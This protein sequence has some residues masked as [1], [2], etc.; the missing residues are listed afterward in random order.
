MQSKIYEGMVTHRRTTPV[1][2][3]F[4][5]KLFMMYI[6][7]DEVNSLARISPFLSLERFNLATFRRRDYHRPKI[8]DLKA[9]VYQTVFEKTGF[10]LNGPVRLLTHLRYFG[11]CMNPVSFYYCFDQAGEKVEAIMAEIE[12]TPWGERFQYVHLTN[13][14]NNYQF[15]KIF[16]VS[17]FFPMDMKYEWHLSGPLNELTIEMNSFK[18]EEKHFNAYLKLNA[19]ELNQSNFHSALLRFPFMT[20]KVIL[21]IYVQAFKLWLKKVPFYSHPNSDS[22]RNFLIFKGDK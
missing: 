20:A 2:H 6:D 8:H 4:R 22:Q 9:A 18:C 19:L 15:Q 13:I 12:N 14:D 1:E 7:L 11:Y 5:Y 17:P 21:G 3:S 10:Q 16:H